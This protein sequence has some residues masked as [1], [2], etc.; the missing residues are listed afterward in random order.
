MNAYKK[1]AQ[2]SETKCRKQPNCNEQGWWKKIVNMPKKNLLKKSSQYLQQ[3]MWM[4]NDVAN[5]SSVIPN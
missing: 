5:G 3:H 1:W 2:K 4:Y